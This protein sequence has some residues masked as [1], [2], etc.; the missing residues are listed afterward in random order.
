MVVAAGGFGLVAE[1]AL[2]DGDV[3]AVAEVVFDDVVELDAGGGLGEIG[4]VGVGGSRFISEGPSEDA[5]DVL[6]MVVLAG[7]LGLVAKDALVDADVVVVAEV[8]F[9]DVVEVDA[10]GGPLGKDGGGEGDP[11]DK[12][13]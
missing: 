4:G 3:V 9:D 11:A 13:E 10:G 12:C 8:G 6:A 5:L 7:L 2:V 1:S